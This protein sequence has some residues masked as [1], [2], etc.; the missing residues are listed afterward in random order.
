M[1]SRRP[2]TPW[3]AWQNITIVDPLHRGHRLGALIKVANL[4]YVLEA[5]PNLEII[6]TGNAYVNS[7][8]ISIN[9][10]MGFQPDL[11]TPELAVTSWRVRSNVRQRCVL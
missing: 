3:H 7:Y 10:E 6:D 9:E 2:E 11:G 1:Y 8:M 5:R 4:R